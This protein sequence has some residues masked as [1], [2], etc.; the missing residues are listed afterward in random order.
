[1]MR[2]PEGLEWTTTAPLPAAGAGCSDLPFTW[3]SGSA[4]KA[5]A[6][7]S[8]SGA[9][10]RARRGLMKTRWRGGRRAVDPLA[11][12]GADFKTAAFLP[13]LPQP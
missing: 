7:V 5:V 2:W 13:L 1:M 3:R 6:P 9:R 12:G 4:A 8:R 11:E 10:R